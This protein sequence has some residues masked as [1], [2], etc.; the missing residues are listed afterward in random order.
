MYEYSGDEKIKIWLMSLVQGC[1]A[2]IY[3]RQP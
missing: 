3:N 2:A 1:R